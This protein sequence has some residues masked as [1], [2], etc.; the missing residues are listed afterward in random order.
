MINKFKSHFKSNYLKNILKMISGATLAQSITI[1]V[2]PLLSRLYTPDQF[3]DYALYLAFVNILTVIITLRYE[4]AIFIP[5]ED[6]AAFEILLATI[7]IVFMLTIIILTLLLFL[8][9]KI[10]VSVF[11][12]LA[13]WTLYMPFSIFFFSV[14]NIFNNWHNRKLRY[15][16]IIRGMLLRIILINL[17]LILGGI[18]SLGSIVFLYA[19][20]LGQVFEVVYFLF[21]ILKLDNE[22][23]RII[24]FR[25]FRYIL[26]RYIN[27]PKFALFSELTNN[28]TAQSPALLFGKYFGEQIVGFFTLTQRVLGLPVKLISK[29]TLEVFKARASY[30]YYNKGTCRPVLLNTLKVLTIIAILPSI[31]FFLYAPDIFVF[32]FGANWHEAGVYAK[33]LSPYFFMQFIVSPFGYILYIVEKQFYNFIWQLSLL[34]TTIIGLSI[35]IYYRSPLISIIMYGIIYVILYIIYFYLSYKFSL[36]KNFKLKQNDI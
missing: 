12:N 7:Y 27:F 22:N 15:N 18:L 30:D 25:K 20:L 5:K 16:N 21:I 24:S 3:G 11:P 35:G 9:N 2:T 1:L 4:H 31:I 36:N 14:Y 34:I 19:N 33:Y 13:G 29:S 32:V 8:G 28:L 23:I 26:I 10:I 6:R 17:I